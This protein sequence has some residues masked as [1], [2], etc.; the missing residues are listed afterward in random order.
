MWYI[1]MSVSSLVF[2]SKLSSLCT[3]WS[4]SNSHV[5]NVVRMS[6]TKKLS[7]QPTSS[8]HINSYKKM[9]TDV[10]YPNVSVLPGLLLEV[11][12]AVHGVVDH[13]TTWAKIRQVGY[14]IKGLSMNIIVLQSSCLW[15][16]E[17]WKKPNLQK[18]T[19]GYHF[20]A[21]W[22]AVMTQSLTFEQRQ[23]EGRSW[24]QN[25]P[26]VCAL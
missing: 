2:S 6:K 7:C 4:T 16:R 9:L 15:V 20:G 5:L 17:G 3:V 26:I 14:Q 19:V 18:S 24:W 22:K 1:L 8:H 10:I 13:Q 21:S 11:V 12:L 23:I 25:W